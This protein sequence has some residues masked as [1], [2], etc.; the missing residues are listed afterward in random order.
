MERIGLASPVCIENLIRRR[1]W[2][3]YAE[4]AWQLALE[5]TP[6]IIAFLG[7]RP[8]NVRVQEATMRNRHQ[9]RKPTHVSARNGAYFAGPGPSIARPSVGDPGFRQMNDSNVVQLASYRGKRRTLAPTHQIVHASVR[10]PRM[11]SGIRFDE[12]YAER[13][14]V[15]AAVFTIVVLLLLIGVW[16]MDGLAPVPHHL[17]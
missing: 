13:M 4:F 10:P 6:A 2:S 7:A 12:D 14:I 16:L 3:T 15:N 9:P 8:S 5:R 1:F 11:W 17:V